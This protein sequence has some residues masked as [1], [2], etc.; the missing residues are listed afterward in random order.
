LASLEGVTLERI[1]FNSADG[2]SFPTLENV[3]AERT[4][5]MTT[6]ESNVS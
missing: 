5:P 4:V 6:V 1:D 3:L 2:Q